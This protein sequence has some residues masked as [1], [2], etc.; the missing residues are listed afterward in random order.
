M[1][2]KT[3]F[4]RLLLWDF[5]FKLKLCSQRKQI[6]QHRKRKHAHENVTQQLSRDTE[7]TQTK[8]KRSSHI[9]NTCRRQRE[10]WD[11]GFIKLQRKADDQDRKH[12]HTNQE[13][14]VIINRIGQRTFKKNEYQGRKKKNTISY[15]E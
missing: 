9:F 12:T 7:K 6:E 3:I 10:E 2:E 5:S 15:T 13:I 1:K 8:K 11:I 4:I 14:S